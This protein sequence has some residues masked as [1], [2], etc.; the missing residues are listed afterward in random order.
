MENGAAFGAKDRRFRLSAII[1]WPLKAELQESFRKTKL[2]ALKIIIGRNHE[3]HRNY[4]AFDL[5]ARK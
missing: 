4:S 2:G 3:S 1:R 5:L